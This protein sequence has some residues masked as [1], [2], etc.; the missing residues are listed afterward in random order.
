MLKPKKILFSFSIDIYG[1]WYRPASGL[2]TLLLIISKNVKRDEIIKN[3]KVFLSKFNLVFNKNIIIIKIYT[4]VFVNW[5]SGIKKFNN[6]PIEEI[7]IAPI[8]KVKKF[9]LSPNFLDDRAR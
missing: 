9:E 3:K 1:K 6:K 7:A 5:L 8:K 2:L 4:K